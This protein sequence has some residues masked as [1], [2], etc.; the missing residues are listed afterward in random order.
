VPAALVAG[1][2]AVGA[3]AF[4]ASDRDAATSVIERGDLPITAA[5]EGVVEAVDPASLGPPAVPGLWNYRISFLAPEG[6]AVHEGDPVLAFDAE[7][8]DR[9]LRERVADRDSGEKEIE[10]RRSDLA[11]QREQVELQLAEARAKLR[12]A[13][14]QLETPEEIMAANELAQQRIDRDLAEAEIEHLDQKLE[15]LDRRAKVEIGILEERR[16]A[17]AV[18]VAQIEGYLQRMK[19]AAPRDGIVIYEADWQGEKKK[20]G[21]QAWPGRSIL[22]I[23]DLDHL[24]GSATVA[25]ADLARISVGQPVS[26]W[27]DAHPDVTYTGR[28]TKIGRTVQR[29]SPQDP[30][31]VVRVEIA[32]DG[33]D[34]ERLRPGLRFR[35][36]AETERLRGV[37]LMPVASVLSTAQGPLVYKK[38]LLGAEAVHPEL[39]RV[40]GER[41]EVLSGLAEGDRV[42][43]DPE[44]VD[45]SGGALGEE[46]ET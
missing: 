43:L 7:E 17:A 19:V 21:D 8:L 23:P 44:R 14:L 24:R 3:I 5:L 2:L 18:R 27:L 15:L 45:G 46:G 38:T 30:R 34:P 22:Q 11:K 6:T 4:G 16:A 25:E 33:S 35:G 1:L 32:F 36:E 9:R 42:L 37:L 28:L 40:S 39:G 10:K 12:R 29:R 41:V 26:V 31:R 13:E 20:V